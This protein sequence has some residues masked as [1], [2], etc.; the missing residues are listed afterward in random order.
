[1]L[2]EGHMYYKIREGRNGQVYWQCVRF[3]SGGCKGKAQMVNGIVTVTDPHNH[4]PNNHPPAEECKTQNAATHKK[5]WTIRNQRI[6][7]GISLKMAL[8][9][10]PPNC[11]L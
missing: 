1:M 11:Y 5:R 7:H 9:S 10:H 2:Y 8:I 6:E 4:P 3:R